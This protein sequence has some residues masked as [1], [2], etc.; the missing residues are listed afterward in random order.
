MV[1]TKKIKLKDLQSGAVIGT[2][3]LRRAVQLRRL[4]P[5]LD[6]KP[7]RGN[8][9]TRIGKTATGDYDAV[10]LAEAGLIRLGL[11]DR[12]SET[13]NLK[14]FIPSPGQ[15]SLAVVCRTDNQQLIEILRTIEDPQSRAEFEAE[16]ALLEQ[17]GGGCRF[18]VGAVAVTKRGITTEGYSSRPNKGNMGRRDS[19]SIILHASIF[20]ADGTKH[21]KLR[22][23]GSIKYAK[24]LGV[25]MGKSL[26]KDGAID[27]A[28]GWREAV[29]K[30]NRMQYVV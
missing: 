25:I 8:V 23:M 20:S 24:Q 2:S 26:I 15:G 13:F 3:S 9:E 7:I 11:V 14:D 4:R 27:M 6:I 1:S 16:R 12:I 17:V 5:D 21:I 30:W 22:K 10:I 19:R 28:K 29:Q 18:P